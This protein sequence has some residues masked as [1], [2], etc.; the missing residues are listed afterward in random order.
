MLVF[1]STY[2]NK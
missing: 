1:Q 2:M